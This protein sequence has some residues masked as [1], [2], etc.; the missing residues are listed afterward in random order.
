MAAVATSA[1]VETEVVVRRDL[2]TTGGAETGV[3]HPGTGRGRTEGTGATVEPARTDLAAVGTP[4]TPGTTTAP[5][6]SG[7]PETRAG[8]GPTEGGGRRK[9]TATRGTPGESPAG[10]GPTDP[11][12]A[13]TRGPREPRLKREETVGP[14]KSS[15]RRTSTR[16]GPELTGTSVARR[17]LRVRSGSSRRKGWQPL[18][19]L[20]TNR[21]ATRSGR[22]CR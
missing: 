5:G 8:T 10:T 9:A 17:D 6:T 2:E 1:E 14:D 19:E 15:R 22:R 7:T 12:G 18:L 20:G 21:A 16:A 11:M 13:G 3:A 4:G